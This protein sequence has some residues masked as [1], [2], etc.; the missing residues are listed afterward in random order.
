MTRNGLVV[1]LRCQPDRRFGGSEDLIGFR[2]PEVRYELR[3]MM[4]EAFPSRDE[5]NQLLDE[6]RQHRKE[7]N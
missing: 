7:S 3:G 6:L 1:R 5:F 4:L 2:H